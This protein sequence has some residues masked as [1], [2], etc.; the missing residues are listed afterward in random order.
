MWATACQPILQIIKDPP[1]YYTIVADQIVE[2]IYLLK[3]YFLLVS[4]VVLVYFRNRNSLIIQLMSL[5]SFIIL[6]HFHIH[7]FRWLPM[8]ILF[9]CSLIFLSFILHFYGFAS[10]LPVGTC[11]VLTLVQ[12]MGGLFILVCNRWC[13]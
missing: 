10:Y 1:K 12:L 2:A 7:S 11:T 13:L 6:T 4:K 8:H 5:E 3:N 9:G